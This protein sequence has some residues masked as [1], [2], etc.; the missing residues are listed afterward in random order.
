MAQHP[1]SLWLQTEPRGEVTVVRFRV[2]EIV[3]DRTIESIGETLDELLQQGRRQLL[4][5]FA[6]VRG[7]ASLMLGKLVGVARRAEDAGG[8]VAVC[9]VHPDVAAVFQ[10]LKLSQLLGIYGSEQE[11]MQGFTA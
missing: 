5:D 1:Q 6:E 4:L 10:S 3:K 9:N 7:V 2:A 8:R 11:A